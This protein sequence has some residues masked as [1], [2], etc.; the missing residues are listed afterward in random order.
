V[1]RGRCHLACVT[2]A[3]VLALVACGG[4]DGDRT[5]PPVLVEQIPAAVK[6]LEARLGGTQRYSE[7]NA[8][9]SEVNLFVVDAEGQESAYVYRDGDL[10]PPPAAQPTQAPTFAAAD[11]AFEPDDVLGQVAEELPHAAVLAFSVQPGASGAA[12]TQMVATVQSAEGGRL[13]VLLGPT[14]E[15][16]GARPEA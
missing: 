2:V 12:G 4:G 16:L 7:I 8:T 5:S 9:P 11:M 3:A 15:I 14:G 1:G 6:A 13:S 10:E